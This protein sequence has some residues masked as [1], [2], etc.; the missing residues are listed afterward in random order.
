[1][2]FVCLNKLR[3]ETQSFR[4]RD[5]LWFFGNEGIGPAFDEETIA[6]LGLNRPAEPT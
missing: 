4:K 3:L 2:F 6:M 1:M 5:G